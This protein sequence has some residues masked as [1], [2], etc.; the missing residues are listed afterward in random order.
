MTAAGRA[1]RRLLRIIAGMLIWASA[2]VFLYAGQSRACSLLGASSG[3]VH[4]VTVL[5]LT[6]ALLHLAILGWL[7]WRWFRHPLPAAEAPDR[8]VEQFC[9]RLEG[10]VLALSIIAL[11]W[12]ATPILMVTPCSG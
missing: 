6:L 4:P 2:L 7:M 8:A 11:L 10:L 9:H 5:L 12:L 1:I 3:S